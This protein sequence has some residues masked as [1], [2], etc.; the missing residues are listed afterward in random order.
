[1]EELERLRKLIL[2][3]IEMKLIVCPCDYFPYCSNCAGRGSYY[4]I[5]FSF[6][7]H[8]IESAECEDQDQ[9]CE[10]REYLQF[11]E[12]ERSESEAA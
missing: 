12:R 5:V 10:N 3:D 9:D 1:M 11:C 2:R 8:S 4:D 7:G 6:C